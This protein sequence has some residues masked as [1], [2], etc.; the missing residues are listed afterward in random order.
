MMLCLLDGG[1]HLLDPVSDE[2][3]LRPKL[4]DDHAGIEGSV[5]KGC[6]RV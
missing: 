4:T 3:E 2:L 6:D 1:F 5:H